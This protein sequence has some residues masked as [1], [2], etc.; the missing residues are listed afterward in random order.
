MERLNCKKG[1]IDFI[2]DIVSNSNFHIFEIKDND[3]HTVF[4]TVNVFNSSV[5]IHDFTYDDKCINY[6]GDEIQAIEK[7]ELSIPIS[8]YKSCAL[9]D[10]K[11]ILDFNIL[12]KMKELDKD[13]FMTI[14]PIKWFIKSFSLED[15]KKRI[16][17]LEGD[18]NAKTSD[19]L[20]ATT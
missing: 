19:P 14:R 3:G 15:V 6:D 20:P 16:T 1:I 5:T 9:K 2:K 18:D 8:L 4:R 13:L 11:F 17:M 10:K 7:Y 12:K